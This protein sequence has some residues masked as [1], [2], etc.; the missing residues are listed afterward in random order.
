MHGKANLLTQGCGERNYS[1]Y[2]RAP[3]TENGQ[4]MLKRLELPDGMRQGFF[5]DRGEGPRMCDHLV[6]NFL[7]GW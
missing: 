3:R 2:C 4:L 7:I 1:V 5:K 6:D